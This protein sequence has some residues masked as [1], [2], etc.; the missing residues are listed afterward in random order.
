MAKPRLRDLFQII[1]IMNVGWFAWARWPER[2]TSVMPYVW[3]LLAGGLAVSLMLDKL[4]E[5]AIA[6]HRQQLERQKLDAGR[7]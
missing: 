7:G 3:L 4:N 5:R 1:V 2:E 6:R